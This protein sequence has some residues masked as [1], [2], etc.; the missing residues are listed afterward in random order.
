MCVIHIRVN[1]KRVREDAAQDIWQVNKVPLSKLAL[2]NNNANDAKIASSC[3]AGELS[4]KP[5]PQQRIPALTVRKQA[6]DSRY[7]PIVQELMFYMKSSAAA[8]YAVYRGWQKS[9]QWRNFLSESEKCNL[10]GTESCR[11]TIPL[12][13]SLS[14]GES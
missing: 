2:A 12:S 5:L 4:A 11:L 1:F 3:G 14:L 6:L 8:I 9:R 13:L 7:T 10:R